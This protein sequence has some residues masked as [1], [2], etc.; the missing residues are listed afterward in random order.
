MN[1]YGWDKELGL[2]LLFG[3]QCDQQESYECFHK[4]R[5][6]YQSFVKEITSGG[7]DAKV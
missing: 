3:T 2:C 1:C 6:G 4:D 5:E 7:E